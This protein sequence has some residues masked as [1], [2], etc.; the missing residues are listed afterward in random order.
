MTI[1]GLNECWNVI[2]SH[3]CSLNQKQTSVVD[4]A[5]Y[6][7][8]ESGSALG[9]LDASLNGKGELDDDENNNDNNNNSVE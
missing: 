2:Q 8:S 9:A 6:V 5:Q 1:L 7:S 3:K 4:H